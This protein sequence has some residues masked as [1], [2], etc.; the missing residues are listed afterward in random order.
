[1][2]VIEDAVWNLCISSYKAASK[3]KHRSF[4]YYNQLNSI[5]AKD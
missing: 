3:F 4:P 2:V 5:Y 1:M